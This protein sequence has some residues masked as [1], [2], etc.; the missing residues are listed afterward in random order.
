MNHDFLSAEIEKL[1]EALDFDDSKQTR[2]RALIDDEDILPIEKEYITIN[3]FWLSFSDAKV[4]EEFFAD[5]S[6]FC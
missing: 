6:V 1:A 4:G 3:E 5:L 2:R